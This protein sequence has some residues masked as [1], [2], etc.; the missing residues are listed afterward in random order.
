MSPQSKLKKLVEAFQAAAA[1][2][3]SAHETHRRGM[4]AKHWLNECRE[5]IGEEKYIEWR[6]KSDELLKALA[7]LL[8]N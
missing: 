1:R 7:P 6:D 8:K 4:L 3:V 2:N 5:F